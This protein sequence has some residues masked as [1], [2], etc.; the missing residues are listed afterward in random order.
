MPRVVLQRR[1]YLFST[2]CEHLK[3][4]RDYNVKVA[5]RGFLLVFV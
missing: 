2:P 5:F 1:E 4:R 3:K